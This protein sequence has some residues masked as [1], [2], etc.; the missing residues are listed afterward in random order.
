MKRNARQGR[1]LPLTE[2]CQILEVNESSLRQW[3]DRGVIRAYR[4]P[5]GHRRFLRDDLMA[6][7]QQQPSRQAA[8][9]SLGQRALRRIRRRLHS[10]R[11]G[12]MPWYAGLHEADRARL[13]F[14]GRRLIDSTVAFLTQ[15]RQK[16]ELLE[17]VRLIGFEYGED[18]V[19]QRLPLDQALEAFIFFRNSLF[20]A[21]R[22]SMGNGALQ[23]HDIAQV[24]PQVELVGDQILRAIILAYGKVSMSDRSLSSQS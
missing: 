16:N 10:D 13:R 11:L 12:D 17:E 8:S 22:E 19:R 20:E 6:L 9:V 14:L 7:F 23:S 21:V 3:A 15:R 24:W 1:W 4:T 5:G 2:A 18:L